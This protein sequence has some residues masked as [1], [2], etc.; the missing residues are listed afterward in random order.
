MKTN[1]KGITI[2]TL[3]IAIIIIVI[4]A[5]VG[6]SFGT[7]MTET[8]QFENIETSLLL[9]QSKIKVVADK[10]AIG[11]IKEEEVYGEKQEEGEYTG[12]YKL[13]QA[14][15]EEMGFKDLKEEDKYYVYYGEKNEETGEYT[16]IDVAYGK[17]IK[18]EEKMYY[19]LSEILSDKKGNE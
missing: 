7:N 14:N 3:I 17:G 1:E 10:K 15:L 8:A 19:K 11:E 12:W 5:G 18:Y 9:I 13:N 16:D 2:I 4:I 6:I